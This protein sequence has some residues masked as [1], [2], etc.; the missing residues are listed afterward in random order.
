MKLSKNLSLAEVAKSA[1]ADRRGIDNTP[2]GKHLENLKLIAEEIFQ[3][4]RDNFKKPI[5]VTSGY[6]SAQLNQLI[7]GAGYWES[8]R[9]I[10]ASQHC[11]GQALDIDGDMTGLDNA[12]IFHYIKDDLDFDQLIWEFGDDK[13]PAWVHVSYKADGNRG[14]I[15]IAKKNS[16]GR[17][18]YERY[19]DELAD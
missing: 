1:T 17:T 14:E 4:L 8:G 3:P 10:P 6:R 13:K 16:K 5:A 19:T 9:Y 11:Y 15:L 7:G 2:K 18:Y 12:K